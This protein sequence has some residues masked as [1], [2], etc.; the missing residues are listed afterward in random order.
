M[1]ERDGNGKGD[2]MRIREHRHGKRMVTLI[3]VT[4]ETRG[5][6]RKQK[7]EQKDRQMRGD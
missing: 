5:G 6:K 7:D 4:M 1:H 2:K 3:G